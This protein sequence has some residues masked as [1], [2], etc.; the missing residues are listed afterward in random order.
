[1]YVLCGAFYFFGNDKHANKPTKTEDYTTC[2]RI[3]PDLVFLGFTSK[4]SARFRFK[5]E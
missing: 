5:Y 2:L 1:M 3:Q 4:F